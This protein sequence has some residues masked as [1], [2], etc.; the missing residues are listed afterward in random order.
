[1]VIVHEVQVPGDVSKLLPGDFV[2]NWSIAVVWVSTPVV[3]KAWQV[4]ESHED[5]ESK[6]GPQ[7][8]EIPLM[9]CLLSAW[10]TCCSQPPVKGCRNTS[11]GLSDIGTVGPVGD[12]NCPMF[13]RCS[14]SFH[15][16]R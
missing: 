2:G 15:L 13:S 4:V 14:S 10:H 11:T 16:S 1:M 12:S 3:V 8:S 6:K 7:L 5:G 9:V